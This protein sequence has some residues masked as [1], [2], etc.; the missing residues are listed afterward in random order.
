MGWDE[1]ETEQGFSDDYCAECERRM[2]IDD[3]IECEL[4]G[5]LSC[6]GC[7]GK[8]TKTISVDQP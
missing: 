5:W 4:C 8:C 7:L 6:E 3:L 2:H 1:D